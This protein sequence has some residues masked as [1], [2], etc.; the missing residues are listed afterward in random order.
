MICVDFCLTD[1]ALVWLIDLLGDVCVVCCL[2]RRFWNCVVS[3]VAFSLLFVL[4][5]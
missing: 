5:V 3:C 4:I 1:I 2:L